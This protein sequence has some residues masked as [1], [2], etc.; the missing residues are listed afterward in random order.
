VNDMPGS[1][2]PEAGGMMDDDIPGLDDA[3][4]CVKDDISSS[5]FYAHMV[6]HKYIY[7]PARTLWPAASVNARLPMMTITD[8][9]GQ[10]V[11]NNKSKPVT[12]AP[13]AWLDKYQP[14]EQMSWAPGLPLIIRDTLVI[15]GGLVEHAGASVFNMYR[16]PEV[17]PG[18]PGQAAKWLEHI[19]YVYPDEADHIVHWL[20][21][22][23]QKPQEKVNHA[24]VLGRIVRH[25]NDRLQS[26]SFHHLCYP[27]Y[28]ARVAAATPSPAAACIYGFLGAG[29]SPSLC[30][31][32][33][34]CSSASCQWSA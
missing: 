11:L 34:T 5:D 9:N 3:L 26:F 15:E 7:V 20:A 12:I 8:A 13:A 29:S 22:R 14:V 2:P 23:V 4:D 10:P 6:S 1:H 18:D 33:A 27:N 21:H 28:G 31:S 24:L 17:L 16:A 30:S 19:R 25:W 32:S